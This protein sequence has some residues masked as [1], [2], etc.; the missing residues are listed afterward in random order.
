ME[1]KRAVALA[2]LVSLAAQL[3]IAV[4][5]AESRR[6]STAEREVIDAFKKMQTWLKNPIE[7]LSSEPQSVQRSCCYPNRASIYMRKQ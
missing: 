5:T 1:D 3:D 7:Y 6:I 2:D 4:R